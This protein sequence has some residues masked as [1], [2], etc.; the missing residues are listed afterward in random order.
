MQDDY[1]N[2]CLLDV[3]LDDLMFCRLAVTDIAR[4]D[5]A[6]QQDLKDQLRRGKD[7]WYRTG[8]MRKD[9]SALLQNNKLGSLVHCKTAD[10]VVWED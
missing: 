2:L 7:S 9:N 5:I 6:E 3:L 8:L 10:W 1:E 4:D